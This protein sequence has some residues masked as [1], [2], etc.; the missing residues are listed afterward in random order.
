MRAADGQARDWTRAS[1]HDGQARDWTRAST[2]LRRCG[3]QVLGGAVDE[4]L[5]EDEGLHE[6]SPADMRDDGVSMAIP[7]VSREMGY[8][9]MGGDTD[10]D[11]TIPF[12]SKFKLVSPDGRIGPAAAAQAALCDGTPIWSSS[13]VDLSRVAIMRH[14]NEW[15][16][17]ATATPETA[18]PEDPE[19]N[20]RG[21]ARDAGHLGV[22]CDGGA[23]GPRSVS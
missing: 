18:A 15:V 22:G 10:L 21:S 14:S 13:R 6:P 12:G 19:P 2:H 11:S 9:F 3:G 16:S 5:R 1:T 8:L 23:S 7:R 17:M 20:Q 4:G